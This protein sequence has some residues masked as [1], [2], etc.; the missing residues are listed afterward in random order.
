MQVIELC[1]TSAKPWCAARSAAR[2]AV[3]A[4]AAAVAKAAEDVHSIGHVAPY[5]RVGTAASG[6]FS[7]RGQLTPAIGLAKVAKM[8]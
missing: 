8:F 2:E 6:R 7:S 5:C 1:P 4:E 3:D